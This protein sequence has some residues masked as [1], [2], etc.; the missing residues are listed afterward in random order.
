MKC[1]KRFPTEDS[2]KELKTEIKNSISEL[3]MS[4]A[5]ILKPILAV[6]GIYLEHKFWLSSKEI[7]EGYVLLR[8]GSEM[9]ATHVL[10]LRDHIDSFDG[11]AIK[12]GEI[13]LYKH[14][15][16]TL[17][18]IDGDIELRRMQRKSKKNDEQRS[19]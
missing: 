1:S 4:I 2:I 6:H 13:K 5:I 15:N 12:E 9:D 18:N 16:H 11:S 3:Q 10:F 8:K 7:E 19:N 14:V 17:R